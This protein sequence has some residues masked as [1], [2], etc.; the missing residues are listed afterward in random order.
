MELGK[1]G[2]GVGNLWRKER[3]V[4]IRDKAMLL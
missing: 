4:A 1:V 2:K 3:T